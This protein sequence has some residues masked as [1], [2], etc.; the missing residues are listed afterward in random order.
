MFH[1]LYG[2]LSFISAQVQE[3]VDFVAR[4]IPEDERAVVLQ[5]FKDIIKTDEGTKN[6]QKTRRH[7]LTFVLNQMKSLGDGSEQGASRESEH[8]PQWM[9]SDTQ[10]QRSRAIST[11]SSLTY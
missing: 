3:L 9:N 5:S 2:A 10:I 7:A 4:T 8:R 1:T 6:D 11:F